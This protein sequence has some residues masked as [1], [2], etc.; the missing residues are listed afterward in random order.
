LS[1][2]L[3]RAIAAIRSGDN[4]LG[5]RLLA[6]VIRS[7]PRNETAWLWMSA[8]IDS[9]E[10]RRDCL[11]RVL[12]INPNN[13]TARRGLEALKQS[14][15]PPRAEKQLMPSADTLQ[16]ISRVE[17]QATKKCPYCA[18]T[19]KAEAVVCRF[20]GKDL[21]GGTQA[22]PRPTRVS[23]QAAKQKP[24]PPKKTRGSRMP[25][26]LGLIVLACVACWAITR[27]TPSRPTA[28]SGSAIAEH[29][30]TPGPK[31]PL[32][33]LAFDASRPDAS[34]EN[35]AESI[36]QQHGAS[37]GDTEIARLPSGRYSVYADFWRDRELDH[38]ELLAIAYDYQRFLYTHP[39]W[40]VGFVHVI[41]EGGTEYERVCTVGA[42][43]GY[44]LGRAYNW[45]SNGVDE[46]YVYLAQEVTD[47]RDGGPDSSSSDQ[48]DEKT[49]FA[50]YHSLC[51]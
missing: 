15:E 36:A 16:R 9:D 5:E 29:T 27:L 47:Y 38:R 3:Q 23:S 1:D 44:E 7:D 2:T 21:A 43:M 48:N 26:L 20:C 33:S 18:E 6:D 37:L 17:P 45:G 10:H 11:K 22:Q 4:E 30:P 42:A 12:A 46:W 39:D 41:V 13:E 50:N 25:V 31:L 51:D 28:P 40:P 19:I 34:F 14:A 32:P 24:P 49:Y 8:V 35:L